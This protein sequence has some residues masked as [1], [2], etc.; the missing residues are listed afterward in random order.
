MLLILNLYNNLIFSTE[1][2]NSTIK[3]SDPIDIPVIKNDDYP[4]A[5]LDFTDIYLRQYMGRRT[6]GTFD[7]LQSSDNRI[8]ESKKTIYSAEH[9]RFAFY[10]SNNCQTNYS[11]SNPS[12]YTNSTSGYQQNQES[13]TPY[14][15]YE[16]DKAA[17]RVRYNLPDISDILSHQPVHSES[18]GDHSQS[19]ANGQKKT[20]DSKQ[21]DS[22]K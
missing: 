1:S 3:R 18:E 10:N 21:V 12:Q 8:P 11:D 7:N 14:E 20:S 13:S 17:V 16:N 5:V 19:S 9:N 6:Y 15:L 2:F 22:S 4:D